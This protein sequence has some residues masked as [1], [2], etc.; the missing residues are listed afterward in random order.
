MKYIIPQ[1]KIDELV[2]KFLDDVLKDLVKKR[3]KYFNGVVFTYPNE[4]H[5]MFGLENDLILWIHEDLINVISSN[6]KLSKPDSESL[7]SQWFSNKY[8]INVKQVKNF[9]L[10]IPNW[11]KIDDN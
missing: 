2:F 10:A 5:G 3:A 7:I 8:Q 6:L 4:K 1:G 9:N 11:L